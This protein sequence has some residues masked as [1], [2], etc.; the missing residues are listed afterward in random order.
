MTAEIQ[1]AN[2]Q[3]AGKEKSKESTREK[4]KDED[5][6]EAAENKTGTWRTKTRWTNKGQRKKQTKT[7]SE[8]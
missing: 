8:K 7:E 1:N 6:P 3:K 4:Y 2:I 5:K